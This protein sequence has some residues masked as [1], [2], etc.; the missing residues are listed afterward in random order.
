MNIV[1][2][3]VPMGSRFLSAPIVGAA[4]NIE[5]VLYT[6]KFY[7]WTQSATDDGTG[8]P[9][10]I[11]P[12]TNDPNLFSAS[13]A[14]YQEAFVH[15][16]NLKQIQIKGVRTGALVDN[17]IFAVAQNLYAPAAWGGAAN[18]TSSGFYTHYELINEVPMFSEKQ[19]SQYDF[20]RDLVL[21]HQGT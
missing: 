17:P 9:M 1:G 4:V 19:A 16:A 15:D 11:K 6:N 5:P 7:Q 20:Q 13:A 12:G 18:G 10:T 14:V 21:Y 3:N 8:A 2:K